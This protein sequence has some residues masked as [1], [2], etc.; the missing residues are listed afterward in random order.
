MRK[1]C[2]DLGTKTCGF[3]ISDNL[4]IIATGLENY[5]FQEKKFSEVIKKVKWYLNESEYKNEIDTIVLGYPLRMDLSKSERTLMVENFK[6]ILAKEIN[7]PII[8]QDE[9][10]TTINAENILQLAG[11]S[12]TKRKTKKDSLAAQLILEDYLASTYN[13]G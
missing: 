5:F 9:R 13:K 3:A 6:L 4:N 10:Q 8:F 11:Y 12:K 2:L 7:L 1:L